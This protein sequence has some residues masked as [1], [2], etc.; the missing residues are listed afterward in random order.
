MKK[1]NVFALIFGT[2]IVLATIYVVKQI[3]AINAL[4]KKT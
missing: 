4:T 3:K 1:E 2:L